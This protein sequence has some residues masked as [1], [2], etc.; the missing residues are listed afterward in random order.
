VDDVSL[1]SSNI[2]NVQPVIC[3]DVTGCHRVIAAV[4]DARKNRP[5]NENNQQK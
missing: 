2:R 1:I 3:L 4:V 5:E